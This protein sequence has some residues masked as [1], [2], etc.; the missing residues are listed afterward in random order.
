[1]TPETFLLLP[2]LCVGQQIELGCSTPLYQEAAVPQLDA[3]VLCD[4]TEARVRACVSSSM[5]SDLR[6][7]LKA[8]NGLVSASSG[9]LKFD[10]IPSLL[11]TS[12]ISHTNQTGLRI[13]APMGC[14]DLASV[15]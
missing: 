11:Q 12:D 14:A 13:Q 7:P 8:S 5:A 9:S 2:A 6:L 3:S 15:E 10:N 4:N 1:M